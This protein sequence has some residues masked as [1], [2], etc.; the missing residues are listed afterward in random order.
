MLIILTVFNADIIYLISLISLS[1]SLRFS[2]QR[3]LIKI[4]FSKQTTNHSCIPVL[5]AG[6][7]GAVDLEVHGAYDQR[8]QR[9]D[10]ELWG[11]K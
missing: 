1:F 6:V 8:E 2:V 5:D 10:E 4:N 7:F 11:E 3:L 9:D